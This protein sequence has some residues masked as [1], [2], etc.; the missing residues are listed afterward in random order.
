MSAAETRLRDPASFAGAPARVGDVAFSYYV[1]GQRIAGDE[2]GPAQWPSWLEAAPTAVPGAGAAAVAARAEA[3][4]RQREAP[5]VA[6]P[7]G[8]VTL[9]FARS[10]GPYGVIAF[11]DGALDARLRAL[12]GVWIELM[13]TGD[14][15]GDKVMDVTILGQRFLFQPLSRERAPKTA[16]TS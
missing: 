12:S 11:H 3:V 15:G 14:P 7:D 8:S 16:G 2:R 5:L 10:G 1:D 13:P 9:A 6:L 4:R